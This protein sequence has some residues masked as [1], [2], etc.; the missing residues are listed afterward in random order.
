MTPALL[1]VGGRVLVTAH[2]ASFANNAV[3]HVPAFAAVLVVALALVE[4]VTKGGAMPERLP[5]L[6]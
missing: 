2:A 4:R 6:I 5:N 1:A 3:A